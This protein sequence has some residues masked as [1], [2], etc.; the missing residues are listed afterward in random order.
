MSRDPCRACRRAVQLLSSSVGACVHPALAA[1]ACVARPSLFLGCLWVGV[2]VC[3]VAVL[4]YLPWPPRASDSLRC[5]P[6][7]AWRPSPPAP[8]FRAPPG[9]RRIPQPAL[10]CLGAAFL[11]R[12]WENR[13]L[14]RCTRRGQRCRRLGR[15]WALFDQERS[16]LGLAWLQGNPSLCLGHPGL[17]PL[18]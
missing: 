16:E 1:Q 3:G 13:F 5:R 4:V 14:S 8:R 11:R 7:S 17:Q 18:L 10:Q 6:R 2:S 15:R 9:T 12:V